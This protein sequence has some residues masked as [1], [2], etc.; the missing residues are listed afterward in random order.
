MRKDLTIV[1]RCKVCNKE[2]RTDTTM[3]GDFLA[4]EEVWSKLLNKS[5]VLSG[6]ITCKT[7]II[8]ACLRRQRC[9]RKSLTSLEE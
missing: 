1:L 6:I 7:C 2:I 9:S 5:V 4:D 8:T 3:K